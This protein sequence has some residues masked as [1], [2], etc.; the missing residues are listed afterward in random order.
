MERSEFQD[1]EMIDVTGDCETHGGWSIKAP[2]FLASRARCPTCVAK[3]REAE[4]RE[5]IAA[6]NRAVEARRIDELKSI[7]IDERHRGKTFDAFVAETPEQ[8]KALRACKSLAERVAVNPTRVP[9]LILC[10]NPG[11][12]KTHLGSAIV[13]HLFDAGV[14]AHRT[15]VMRILR[16]IKSSWRKGSEH[17]EQATIE[18]LSELPCL[19]IDEIGVQFGSDT[20]RM[21]LFEIIDRRYESCLPTVLISNLDMDALRAEMGERV[22][23]RLREDKG[24]LLTFTGESWRKSQ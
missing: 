23:D 20:E 15:T 22:I 19:V 1:I 9:S 6:K 11:T 8:A 16:A 21:Y 10:G 14:D 3:A 13:Q 4:E 2:S 5:A 24:V 12:G 18:Y 7:G 17:D